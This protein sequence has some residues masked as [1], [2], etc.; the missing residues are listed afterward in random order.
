MKA[1]G[2]SHSGLLGALKDKQESFRKAALKL[3][4]K[5]DNVVAHAH[6]FKREHPSQKEDDGMA[7]NAVG[8]HRGY[9]LKSKYHVPGYYE[10]EKGN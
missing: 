7:I 4:D 10:M 6:M 2:V 9:D 3:G 8:R 5:Y 1:A